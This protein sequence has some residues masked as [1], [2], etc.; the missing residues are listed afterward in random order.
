MVYNKPCSARKGKKQFVFSE[1]M[2]GMFLKFS[3]GVAKVAVPEGNQQVSLFSFQTN[4]S[5]EGY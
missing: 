2:F 1:H 5:S 4:G 3:P